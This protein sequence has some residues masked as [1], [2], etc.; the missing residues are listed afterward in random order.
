MNSAAGAC[1]QHDSVCFTLRRR[2]AFSSSAHPHFFFFS[3]LPLSLLLHRRLLLPLP[4][5]GYWSRTWPCIWAIHT[6]SDLLEPGSRIAKRSKMFI[7]LAMIEAELSSKNG[8]R[9]GAKSRDKKATCATC[10]KHGCD[11]ALAH[12]FYTAMTPQLYGDDVNGPVGRLYHAP[13]SIQQIGRY[14]ASNVSILLHTFG[15]APETNGVFTMKNRMIGEISAKNQSTCSKDRCTQTFR[16]FP[17][18]CAGGGSWH[19]LFPRSK[20]VH[21]VSH[22]PAYAMSAVVFSPNSAFIAN[23]QQRGTSLV[24]SNSIHSAVALPHLTGEKWGLLDED[25]MFVQRCGSCNYGGPALFQVYNTSRVWQDPKSVDWWFMEAPGDGPGAAVLG[26]AAMRAAWGGTN[27][28]NATTAQDI[29]QHLQRGAINLVDTWSPLIIVAADAQTY[30]GGG[31]AG[32]ANFTTQILATT[33]AVDT[34]K[35]SVGFKWHGRDFGFAP[36]PSTWKGEWTLPTVNGKTVENDPPFMYS[37]PHLNA[38]LNTDVVTATYGNYTLV[39]D[40]SDDTITR[41]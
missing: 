38:A 19:T 18:A 32:L 26:W 21:V 41:K 33:V 8:I 15:A 17:C 39:Y 35:S 25:V 10:S 24:F 16:P 7:D 3:A 12:H 36:G 23:S 30:G 6:L 13:I 31:A 27:F 5:S 40:F 11:P 14:K 37:S 9:A 1:V 2:A 28:T 34:A 4:C 20:Q 22:T 29:V